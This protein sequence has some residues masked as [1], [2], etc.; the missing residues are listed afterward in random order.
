MVNNVLAYLWRILGDA[1]GLT[2]LVGTGI[3]WLISLVHDQ[4]WNPPTWLK[5]TAL[6]GSFVVASYRL[7]RRA[8]LSRTSDAVAVLVLDAE[9]LQ[10]R[11]IDFV[12]RYNWPLYDDG[13][14][15]PIPFTDWNLETRDPKRYELSRLWRRMID[16]QALVQKV[17]R[18]H[19]ITEQVILNPAE[20]H[21]E[22]AL[23]RIESYMAKLRLAAT[24]PKS[25]F[26]H[27]S[28]KRFDR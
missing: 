27:L 4:N 15:R 25:L 24:P 1:V 13:Q 17:F 19:G 5:W 18:E 21:P 26:E 16:H 28:T 9:A 11:I 3:L 12:E 2:L 6:G 22:T 20:L 8:E 7:V 10:E 23:M 14:L